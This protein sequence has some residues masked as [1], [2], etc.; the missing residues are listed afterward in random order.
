MQDT[1]MILML[2]GACDMQGKD[3]SGV[4]QYMESSLVHLMLRDPV[5]VMHQHVL[6]AL[7][8]YHAKSVLF[9]PHIL[10]FTFVGIAECKRPVTTWLTSNCKCAVCGNRPA[11]WPLLCLTSRK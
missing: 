3:V 2:H 4:K 5:A 1:D 8:T 9:L 7:Q 11:A 10:T 6:P